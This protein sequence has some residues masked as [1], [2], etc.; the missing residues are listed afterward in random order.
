ME[1]KVACES[2]SSWLKLKLLTT[3]AIQAC[4]YWYGEYRVQVSLPIGTT[5]SWLFDLIV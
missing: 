5:D 3:N 1:V 2:E 4:D